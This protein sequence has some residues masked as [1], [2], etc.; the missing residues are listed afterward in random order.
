MNI[1]TLRK[2][3][4]NVVLL[5][6]A[7]VSGDVTLGKDCS[8]WYNAVLRGDAEPICVGARTNI[9]DNCV[10]HTSR[11]LPLTVGSGVTV[12]H[13]AIL[14]SCTIGDNTLIG[15]G[16]IVL[17]GA[18]VGRDCVI[19]AGSLVTGGTVIPE[20]SMAF[21]RP[22]RVVRPLRPEEIEKNRFMAEEYSKRK[23]LY[24]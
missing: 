21:G 11:G 5:P 15:M 10:L 4:E 6:G 22:A 2:T 16:S 14:H 18:T 9:Q 20:G 12:G 1:K 13:A 19:G 8:I 3:D 7:M 23:E 17:D 24:R